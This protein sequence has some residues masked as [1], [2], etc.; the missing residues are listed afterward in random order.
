ML[1]FYSYKNEF[2]KETLYQGW[3]PVIIAMLISSFAGMVLEYAIIMY[4]GVAVFQP[5]VNGVGGNLVGIF[6][7][8]LSTSLHKTAIMGQRASWA[9]RGFFSLPKQTFFGKTSNFIRI[10]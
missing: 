6:A 7:S 2:V 10:C 5:V 1:A 3:T 8:R 9:P 4:D